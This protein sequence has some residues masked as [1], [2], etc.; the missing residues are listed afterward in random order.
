M[1]LHAGISDHQLRAYFGQFG[2]IVEVQRYVH[3]DGT[4]LTGRGHIVFT[5]HC[6]AEAVKRAASRLQIGD[7]K[8]SLVIFLPTVRYEHL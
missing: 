4:T 5:T 8:L 6:A 7:T 2:D 3:S 1:G